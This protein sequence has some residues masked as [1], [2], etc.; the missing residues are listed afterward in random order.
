VIKQLQKE[1]YIAVLTHFNRRGIRA[2]A[3]AKLMREIIEKA[4]RS[5]AA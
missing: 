4:A 3:P 1:G 2:N 5:V